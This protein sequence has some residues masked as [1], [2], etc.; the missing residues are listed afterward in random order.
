MVDVLIE[1]VATPLAI[2]GFFAAAYAVTVWRDWVRGNRTTPPRRDGRI[3]AD[4]RRLLGDDWRE[5][6]RRAA[7]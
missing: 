5:C 7:R 3:P 2:V 1:G 4:E 6:L